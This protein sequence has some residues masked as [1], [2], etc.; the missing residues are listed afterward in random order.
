MQFLMSNIGAD[1][2][3]LSEAL[4]ALGSFSKNLVRSDEIRKEKLL[5]ILELSAQSSRN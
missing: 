3:M 1:T 2:F 4:G 5:A